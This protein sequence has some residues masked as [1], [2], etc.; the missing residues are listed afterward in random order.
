MHFI[1]YDKMYP[2]YIRQNI[3][4]LNLLDEEV[5]YYLML[6]KMLKTPSLELTYRP[7]F[8]IHISYYSRPPLKTLTTGDN[9]TNNL[10]WGPYKKEYITRYNEIKNSSIGNQF[11]STLKSTDIELRRIIQ[12]IELTNFYVFKN[13]LFDYSPK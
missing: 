8:G 13:A 9:E 4:L 11:F 2:I 6:Y 3:D 12:F 5:L 7:I 1:E 10:C